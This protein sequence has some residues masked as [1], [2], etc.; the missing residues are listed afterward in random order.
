MTLDQRIRAFRQLGEHLENLSEESFESIAESARLENPW[1][2][3]ENVRRSLK[4]IL[5][6]LRE[7]QLKQWTKRYSLQAS[8]QKTIALVMAGNIPLV[9]F[10]D[11]I[12]VLISGNCAQVKLSSKDSK[13]TQHLINFL[14]KIEP[15]FH[16]QI[17]YKDKLEGFDAII[18]T[19]SDNAARYFE[20][21]FG[22]YPNII[23][24]N[25]TS[26]AI[27]TGGESDADI[28]NLGVDVFSYFGLGC[29]N[30]S[31]LYVP[32]DYDFTNLLSRWD[33]FKEVIHHH[34][35]S[36]NYD[37]QK[38]ILLVNGVHHLDNGFVL[39]QENEKLVSPI[40][41]L[42]YERYSSDDDL[43]NKLK[44]NTEKIQCVVGKGKLATVAFGQAQ[45]PE[46]W[47][48]A[49]QIDTLKFLSELK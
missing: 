13:L 6:F 44:A 33:S 8:P 49:D 12:C 29:R 26:C 10:H 2:T 34:K 35:Y 22:K 14:V 17:E 37:Y 40:S 16:D 18:A 36:N 24:K 20:Y 23:R 25:R 27:L 11:L 42:Y 48:Y 21:Y 39:L 30:V 19:G 46:V 43:R 38:S 47:D 7:D 1:F 3:K 15:A 41:V 9:G 5:T 31:K 32:N 4:G 45:Y 28:E